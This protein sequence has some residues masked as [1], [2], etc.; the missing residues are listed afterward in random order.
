MHAVR[1]VPDRDFL[2]AAPRP[3]TG[4]HAA[5]DDAVQA[6]DR[7]RVTAEP[8]GEDRH[9]E[10]LVRVLR[11]DATQTDERVMRQSEFVR[12]GADV[13]LDHVRIEA[14]M[15]GRHRRVRREHSHRG[16]F[17]KSLVE[18][19]AVLLHPSANEFKRRESRVAFIHVD[20]ARL[21]P[22]RV[23]AR[24]PPM[25]RMISCRIRVLWSPP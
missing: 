18:A 13:L 19:Q 2:F 9:A 15:P 17:T 24:A 20:H 25:P 7:I 12:E 6:G 14:V 16:R 21:N 22:Q 1:N 3:Q 10:R 23:K 4:P 5:A 8:E 11:I